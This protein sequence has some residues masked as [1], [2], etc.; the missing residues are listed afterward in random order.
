M[1]AGGGV[2]DA[3]AMHRIT[4]KLLGLLGCVA[5]P[6]L[7]IPAPLVVCDRCGADFVNP[8]SWHEADDVHWWIRLRC[9]QC[10]RVRE[11]E[12]TDEQAQGY[13]REL[14]RG[15]AAVAAALVRLEQERMVA[16]F[17]TLTAALERDLIG[18]DDFRR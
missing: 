4:A 13:D 8:V 7:P 5:G 15:A 17:D 16:D 1:A 18:P 10:G 11:V 9:G 14:A 12:L 3:A 6:T 2:D